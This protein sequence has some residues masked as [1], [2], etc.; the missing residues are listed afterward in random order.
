M[1]IIFGGQ[2]VKPADMVGRSPI[3]GAHPIIKKQETQIKT[4]LNI[5]F[6]TSPNLNSLI[7][8]GSISTCAI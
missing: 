7:I 1:A 5:I 3:K 6:I 8:D 4:V 2:P